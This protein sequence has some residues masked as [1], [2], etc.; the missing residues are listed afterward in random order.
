MYLHLQVRTRRARSACCSC[1]D[2]APAKTSSRRRVNSRRRAALSTDT[3]V[4]TLPV[5]LCQLSRQRGAEKN[6]VCKQTPLPIPGHRD[7][8]KQAPASSLSSAGRAKCLPASCES[9]RESLLLQGRAQLARMRGNLLL[10][11]SDTQSLEPADIF[12]RHQAS[13]KA[14]LSALSTR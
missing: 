9:C 12:S 1:R 5:P 4:N 14:D 11:A 8:P 10:W 6:T 7:L 13:F 2:R 3:L